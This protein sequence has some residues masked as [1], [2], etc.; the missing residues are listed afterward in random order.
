MTGVQTRLRNLRYDIS[1]IGGELNEETEAALKQFQKANGLEVT[2]RPD[3]NTRNK[4]Q[5]VHGS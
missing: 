4:L 5:E 1:E 2:G 3:E